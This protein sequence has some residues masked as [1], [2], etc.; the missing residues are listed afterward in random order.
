MQLNVALE[1][2]LNPDHL[3]LIVGIQNSYFGNNSVN[4]IV[5]DEH[6]DGFN[7]LKNS[8]IEFAINEPLHLIEQFDE[9]M[10]DLGT[11]FKTSG[12]VALTKDAEKKLLQ[13]EKIRISSPV[14]NAVTNK[15][16][17]EILKSYALKFDVNIKKENIQIEAIDFYHINNIKNGYD[18]AWLVFYNFEGVEAR[19]EGVDI[20]II[21]SVLADVPN[22]AALDIF[23]TKSFFNTHKNEVLTFIDGI[24]ESIEYI[25]NNKE[26]AKKA[27]YSF[28]K[29]EPSKLMDAIIDDTIN[30]FD[31]H[32]DSDS[33]RQRELLAFFNDIGVSSLCF[34]N[35][36][37]AFLK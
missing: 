35:F 20:V 28:S 3:P 18:G 4:I 10:L 24:K 21:D 19:L 36:K 33:N 17:F 6:Y 32:F 25:K 8:E 29:E 23:T 12:G 11:F 15:V 30:R 2:F 1:W 37:G 14:S 9:N 31:Q 5:P 34:D 22:F 27:Y 7:A 13:G 16:A 26:E